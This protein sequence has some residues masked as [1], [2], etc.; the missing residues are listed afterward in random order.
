MSIFRFL[1]KNII[2]DHNLFILCV[3]FELIFLLIFIA[4]RVKKLFHINWDWF[5]WHLVST[6]KIARKVFDRTFQTL[7]K[8]F[9]QSFIKDKSCR[10]VVLIL[11]LCFIFQID[12][13]LRWYEFLQRFIKITELSYWWVWVMNSDLFLELASLQFFLD[14]NIIYPPFLIIKVMSNWRDFV[15]ENSWNIFV[16]FVVLCY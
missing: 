12:F 11:S 15:H 9:V 3:L 8:N 2:W 10:L 5:V 7:R 13:E 6:E 1:L 16:V 4:N 14:F